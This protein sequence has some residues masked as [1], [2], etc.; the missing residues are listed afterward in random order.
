MKNPQFDSLVWGSL[1]LAPIIFMR[2]A[3]CSH[4]ARSK[5]TAVID[6]VVWASRVPIL[7]GQRKPL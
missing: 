6:F 3:F 1:T 7:Q 2:I 4:F 5:Q